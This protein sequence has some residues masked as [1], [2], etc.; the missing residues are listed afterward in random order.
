LEEA[1]ALLKELLNVVRVAG[2]LNMRAVN[3]G[4]SLTGILHPRYALR[5]DI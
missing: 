5:S 2:D 3:M 4:V 1:G